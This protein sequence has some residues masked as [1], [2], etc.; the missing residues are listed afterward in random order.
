MAE[1]D[2]WAT[3]EQGDRSAKASFGRASAPQRLQDLRLLAVIPVR[4]RWRFW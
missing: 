2:H 4:K 3:S 1:Q